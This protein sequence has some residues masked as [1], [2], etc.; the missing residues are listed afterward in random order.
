MGV[1]LAV[2][3]TD[4][5]TQCAVCNYF[6]VHAPPC[7]R[8]YRLHS[9]RAGESGAVLLADY[10]QPV[11]L[12]DPATGLRVSLVVHRCYEA[13][14]HDKVE[15]P[16]RVML[17]TAEGGLQQLVEFV[18]A[19]ERFYRDVTLQS[20]PADMCATVVHFEWDYRWERSDAYPKRSLDTLY[21][22]TDIARE[23]HAE[24]TEF[25]S[26][27]TASR[28]QQ[29]GIPHTRT[30]LFHGLPGSGKSSLIFAL[31]S[32]CDRNLAVLE[33]NANMTDKQLK[34]AIHK[35]PRHC[36]LVLEDVDCLFEK[37]TQKQ[38]GVTF[39]GLL[40]SLDGMCVCVCCPCIFLI[41]FCALRRVVACRGFQRPGHR[42]IPYNQYLGLAGH[43][44][45]TQGGPLRGIRALQAGAGAEDVPTLFPTA[46]GLV[47]GL[48]GHRAPGQVHDQHSA[49][50]LLEAH[51]LP[52]HPA[53]PRRLPRHAQAVQPHRRGAVR[54]VLLGFRGLQSRPAHTAWPWS[55]SRP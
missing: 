49:K 48:L 34:Q 36:F 29:L 21:F 28:Y 38:A 37:R 20:V 41:D 22:P 8:Q 14:S 39:S 4:L 33:F 2:E 52:R 54:H 13:L 17:E 25:L 16:R 19:C 27:R 51:R 3:P 40:N 11:A 55:A 44:N 26:E 7:S 47:Q 5:E 31:A 6:A 9:N 30:Y 50:V 32:A 53:A 10:D 23:L 35:V 15:F 24:L 18:L 12:Q 45:E 46:T 42:G 1:Q 43:G